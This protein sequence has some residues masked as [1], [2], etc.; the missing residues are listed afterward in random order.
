MYIIDELFTVYN[1]NDSPP[2]PLICMFTYHRSDIYC[3]VK[4]G[5]NEVVSQVVW[6][7]IGDIIIRVSP[8]LNQSLT[9]KGI[10]NGQSLSSAWSFSVY[11]RDLFS[12][13]DSINKNQ[14]ITPKITKNKQTVVT[15]LI[16]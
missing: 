3:Y 5:V 14:T 2:D 11:K 9:V 10:K 6:Y 12:V 13:K 4:I 7:R 15:T 8:V 1:D 16:R